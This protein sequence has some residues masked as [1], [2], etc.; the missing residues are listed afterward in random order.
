MNAKVAE[1]PT[2]TLP[3]IGNVLDTTN[4]CHVAGGCFVDFAVPVAR[5]GA[6]VIDWCEGAKCIE[7]DTC[8]EA[9]G[10]C[11]RLICPE[12]REARAA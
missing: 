12:C 4:V 2:R 11:G 3:S 7:C 9:C 6:E 1:P 10:V 8:R 5:C